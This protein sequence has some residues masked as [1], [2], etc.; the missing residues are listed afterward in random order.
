MTILC[1]FKVVK[2]DDSCHLTAGMTHYVK[3]R[4]V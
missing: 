4:A 3:V 2:D 1:N